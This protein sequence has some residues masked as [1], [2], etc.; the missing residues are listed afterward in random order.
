MH[1]ILTYILFIIGFVFLIKGADYLIDGASSIAK[2][3]NISD[4]VIGLT[5][6]ALGTSAPELIVNIVASLQGSP[7]IAI[8]NVI[9]SNIAN[10][11]LVL[12]IAS[13]I[14]P[15]SVKQSTVSKEIPFSLLSAI[16]LGLVANDVIFDQT[17]FSVISRIDGILFIS[18]FII[19]I[20]YTFS[21]SKIPKEE[22]EKKLVQ[23]SISKS[24]VLIILGCIGL[25]VG[26]KWIVD[27]AVHI[28]RS[29]GLSESLIALTVI[30]V[31]TTLPEITTS[32]MAAL[33]KNADIAVGNVIG[34]NIF[35]IFFVLGISSI[36]RPIPYSTMNNTDIVVAISV[37]LILLIF[38]FTGRKRVINRWKGITFLTGY[39]S[40][41]IFLIRRG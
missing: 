29:F 26:G 15:L 4:L 10:I 39:A 35:N 20:Y 40:Y 22:L 9:G 2:R 30:A 34:S 36:I 31:G 8:G 28:A 14:F 16:L 24:L 25:A 13:L 21:I 12:G 11:C 41:V 7:Q 18:F 33:K 37:H 3:F 17:G 19:F 38:M 27:G 5:I 32:V 23:Y 1:A 6:V